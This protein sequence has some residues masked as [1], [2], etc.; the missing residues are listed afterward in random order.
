MGKHVYTMTNKQIQARV[1]R[2]LNTTAWMWSISKYV[3]DKSA[4]G[5]RSHVGSISAGKFGNDVPEY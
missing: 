5:G 4:C 1:K 3:V 2:L